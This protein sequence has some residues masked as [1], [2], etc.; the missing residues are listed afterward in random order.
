MSKEILL[1]LTKKDKEADI[2]NRLSAGGIKKVFLCPIEYHADK[3][4]KSLKDSVGR[5]TSIDTEIVD[6]VGIFNRKAFDF[7]EDYINF[8]H[9]AGEKEFI[10]RIN[11]KEYFAYPSGNFSLWW[12][13]LISEKN[14]YKS[15]SF[16]LFS[17]ILTILHLKNELGC[18]QVWVS[19]NSGS[20]YH[21]ISGSPNR[22]NW[23]Q[24]TK[25]IF[26]EIIKVIKF[27]LTLLRKLISLSKVKADFK[28]YQERIK[29]C[30]MVLVT[31]FP[32]VDED[33]LKEEKFVNLAYG[34]LQEAIEK[35]HK[36]KVAWLGMF[37]HINSSGWNQALKLARKVK[38]IE[39]FFMLEEWLKFKDFW[40]IILTYLRLP[41]RTLRNIGKYRDHFIYQSPIANAPINFWEILREDFFSS[42]LGK[43]LISGITDYVIFSNVVENLAP[44][45]KVLYFAEMHCWEKALN[46]SRAKGKGIV[47]IGLQHTIVPLLL[48]NYF[49]H[50]Q[51]IGGD[52]HYTK[53]VPL[54]DYLGCVG[55][56]TKDMFLKNG[57]PEEK[58]FISGGFRF[59]NL[60]YKTDKIALR[61]KRKKQIVVSFSI[62]SFENQEMLLLLCDAFNN[63]KVDFTI[64]LKSH[65]CDS[66]EGTAKNMGLDINKEIFKFTDRP[67]NDIIPGS[68]AMVVKES[69]SVF[70]A[71]SNK[72][73]IIVP[74]FYNIGDICPLSG[75]SNLATY[76][77]NS[78]ELFNVVCDIMNSSK[79]VDEGEYSGFL[80]EYLKI[81]TDS[82]QYYDTLLKSTV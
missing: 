10:D 81:H 75:I 58:L 60:N 21:I 12:F 23:L 14:P 8:I 69:S 62:S 37:A 53:Y 43:T 27:V 38:K 47:S 29:D 70:W 15:P 50:P 79:N 63:R 77:K 5:K 44:N 28:N 35:N 57:W 32:F 56:I 82:K 61:E 55:G 3:L 1:V 17:K 39:L 45:T 2:L 16:T 42:F 19:K 20:I 4:A 54:P 71:I 33:K 9:E 80:N 31:M 22:N 6:F 73:P 51:A 78:K 66:V 64:L 36:K 46:A 48:L 26:I 18:R 52:N 65:S 68:K 40:R 67:L 59:Y 7:K 72:I 49:D 24:E 11:L 34:S 13:S 30:D 25:I 41:Y 74:L 76:V